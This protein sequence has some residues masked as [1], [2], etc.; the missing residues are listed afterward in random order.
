VTE[1]ANT[2]EALILVQDRRLPGDKIP[3]VSENRIRAE[4][5]A[6]AISCDAP[7]PGK[8]SRLFSRV[9]VP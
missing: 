2:S 9:P 4:A 1:K 8:A 6:E 3:G 5:T 7:L